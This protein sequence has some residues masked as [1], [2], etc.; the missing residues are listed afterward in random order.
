VGSIASSGAHRHPSVARARGV[1]DMIW[2]IARVVDGRG[3][4][5]ARVEES[6]LDARGRRRVGVMDRR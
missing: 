1:G 2:R 3:G 6:E 4:G 5:R